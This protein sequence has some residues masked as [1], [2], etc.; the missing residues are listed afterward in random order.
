MRIEVR[1]RSGD[2]PVEV[3]SGTLRTLGAA[4]RGSGVEGR[5]AVVTD[6]HVEALWAGPVLDSL[7]SAG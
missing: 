4:L 3:G 2:Y 5:V 6:R 1:S 7:A